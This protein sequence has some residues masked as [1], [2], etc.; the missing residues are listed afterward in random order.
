M[1]VHREPDRAGP[2]L[3]ALY[4]GASAFLFPSLYE[5]FGLPAVE[6]MACGT[7]VVACRAGALP[8][9]MQLTGGGLLV[10]K[11]DPAA[12]AKGIRTLFEQPEKRADLGQQAR[13]RV[14]A[15]L[16]WRR[17]A[18]VTAEGYYEV[19]AERRGCPTSTITSASVGA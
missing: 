8:E 7:P 12:L 2:Q 5:G 9:V 16:S 13:A 6:A 3:R 1:R 10:E 14:E 15:S 4:A 11:D 19:L 17:V 18:A